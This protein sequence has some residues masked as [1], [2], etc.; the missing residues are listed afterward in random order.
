MGQFEFKGPLTI[1]NAGALARIWR[2][3]RMRFSF[4]G[5][6]VKLC[7]RGCPRSQS[8]VDLPNQT[9]TNQ[10]PGASV[11]QEPLHDPPQV[12]PG[13]MRPHL[14]FGHRPLDHFSDFSNRET[15]DV[16]QRQH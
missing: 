12:G 6:L 16:Q 4:E 13:P 3:A 15:L 14:N 11:L 10:L 2:A 5:I 8:Q 1:G 9:Q 7:G